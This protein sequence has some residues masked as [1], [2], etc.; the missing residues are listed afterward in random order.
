MSHSLHIVDVFAEKPLTGNQLA[1]VFDAD[2]LSDQ[3]MGR[4]AQEMNF[5]DTTF[6]GS[7][8][9]PDG[10]YR[11][12]IFTPSK[13]I[14]FAGH[15]ILG[16]AS[17]IRDHIVSDK[18]RPVR[19]N[20]AVGQVSVTFEPVADGRDVAWFDSPPVELGPTCAPG[21]IAEAL[22]L[23]PSDVETKTPIQQFS[24][25]VSAILVP[26]RNLEALKKSRLDLEAFAP[27]AGEGFSPLVYLFCTETHHPENDLCARFFF[28]AHGV[29][30]DPATGNAA[31][32][33]GHYLL[34]HR[35][36]S[37]TDLFLRI[38]QGYEI[39]RP[40]LVLLRAREVGNSREVRIGGSVVPVA[41]G[42]LL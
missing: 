32:F 23:A 20:L 41:Q 13:E 26:L 5:S 9:E 27:L 18:S 40:S 31:A 34:E 4:I 3:A 19:L 1:V 11:V 12:R 22:Q 37:A 14:A 25:G 30:E 29:R 38:E 24:A 28:V 16:T 35:F 21:R 10:A 8:P 2:D 33:L 39:N 7:V 36:F 6:V 17:I 42:K 15:P